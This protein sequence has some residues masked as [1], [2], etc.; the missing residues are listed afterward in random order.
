MNS[1]QLKDLEKELWGAADQL[2][3]D[4][5]LKPTE[6]YDPVLGLIILLGFFMTAIFQ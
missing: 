1:Q 4:S 6:Y 5:K 3:A 2:R